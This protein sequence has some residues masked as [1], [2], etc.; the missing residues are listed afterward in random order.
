MAGITKGVE[1]RVRGLVQ[2]VGFRPS[3]WHLAN[4]C[5]VTGEVWNDAEGVLIHAWGSGSQ[6]DAFITRLRNEPPPLAH[7][8][9]VESRVLEEGDA[10]GEFSIVGS[11]QGDVRTGVVPDAATCGACLSDVLDP[12][13]R[14]YRYPFTNCTHCGPRL[15]IVRAIP[16]D[17]ATTS[18]SVFPQC[19]ACQAEYDDPADRRFHAQPNACGECGPEVWLENREGERIEP[20]G[21]EDSIAH[22]A[23]LIRQGSIVAIK[24]IG[25]VHLACDAGNSDAVDRLRQRKRRY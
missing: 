24:G 1:I 6:I 8:E 4:Q 17:R 20:V 12:A 21:D 2:G 13:N 3:V 11:R 23:R 19:P 14:R 10:P 7:I 22:A 18:M 9:S 16:Y 5:G 25:G 15:S